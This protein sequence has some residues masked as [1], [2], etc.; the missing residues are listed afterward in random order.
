MSRILF[1][2][3]V[4]LN[5]SWSYAQL[6]N[7]W[8]PDSIYINRNVKTIYVYEN[9]PKDLSEI[10][11]FDKAGKRIRS[12]KYSAS[13]NRRTRKFKWTD[14]VNI[15][16]YNTT[17]QLIN[18]KD[19]IGIDSMT[20]EYNENGKLYF[21]RKNSGNFIYETE[22]FYAPLKTITT[23]KK[24][25]IILY[26]KTKEYDKEFY[27]NRFYRFSLEPK[28]KRVIDSV[29]GNPTTIAYK[30][31]KDLEKFND[32]VAISNFFN[33]EGQLIKSYI[34]SIFM[35]DRV[36]KY[37]LKYEYDKKG[38]LKSIIG[39]VPLYFKYEYFE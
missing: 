24:D 21:S 33:E 12:I 29:N 8:Q 13:Y 20:F 23:R 11:E 4:F 1:L 22:Y 10:V 34:H 36:N 6:E 14:K 27:I 15:Y 2:V 3:L 18:I 30:D 26:Q 9:S 39:Y 17:D 7:R 5:A 25:S 37:E 38:L 28:L 32:D 35:N 16:T 19:S 31:Y